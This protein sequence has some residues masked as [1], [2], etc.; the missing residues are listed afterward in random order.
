VEF[1]DGT[2]VPGALARE[3]GG[4][5]AVE[6]IVVAGIHSLMMA[7]FGGFVFYVSV[8]HI[9]T[10]IDANSYVPA[11]SFVL[12]A[13]VAAVLLALNVMWLAVPAALLVMGL[14]HLRQTTRLTWRPT[15]AWIGAVAASVAI[16]WL[17]IYFFNHWDGYGGHTGALSSRRSAS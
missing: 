14:M 5:V 2:P 10:S 16:G 6:T 7:A 12:A 8:R 4:G 1:T 3:P 17:N 13:P 9:S 15:V 11:S